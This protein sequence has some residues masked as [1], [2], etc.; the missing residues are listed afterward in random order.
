Q[1][2]GPAVASVHPLVRNDTTLGVDVTGVNLNDP[3][4]PIP[5]NL[6]TGTKWAMH[7]GIPT[8]MRPAGAVATDN[9]KIAFTNQ[10]AETGLYVSQPGIQTLDDGRVQATLDIV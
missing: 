1:N 2:M 3:T 7:D 4:Q 10:G 9:P 6:L 5:P 8:V